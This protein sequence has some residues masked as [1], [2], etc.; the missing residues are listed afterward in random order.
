[1]FWKPEPV[2]VMRVP[3]AA[4]PALGDSDV[5]CGRDTKVNVAE[6]GEKSMP[7]R[8]TRMPTGPAVALNGDTQARAVV[9]RNV[10]G[11]DAHEPNW[12]TR[13]LVNKKLEPVTVTTVPPDAGPVPGETPS[14]A[15]F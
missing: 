8:E 9:F 1:V 15:S 3:P 5:T 6:E 12:Q 10:A 11:T 7:F 2:T 13:F 4:E 14:T